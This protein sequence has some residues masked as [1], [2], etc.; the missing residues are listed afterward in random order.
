MPM[1]P[2]MCSP[3][4]K[5]KC[6]MNGSVTFDCKCLYLNLYKPFAIFLLS[7][8]VFYNYSYETVGTV[9]VLPRIF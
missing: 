6:A 8:Q 1:Y 3:F 7:I 2:I 4:N 9:R 5:L